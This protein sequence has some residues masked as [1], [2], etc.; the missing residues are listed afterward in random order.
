VPAREELVA[1]RQSA[2][3]LEPMRGA[4]GG[5]HKG[6]RGGGGAL[7]TSSSRRRSPRLAARWPY[8]HAG[9]GLR[10]RGVDVTSAAARSGDRTACC[11]LSGMRRSSGAAAGA[12]P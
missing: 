9:G 6:A 11:S 8:A 7:V 5:A 4:C 12:S 3:N 2:R 1:A 10:R